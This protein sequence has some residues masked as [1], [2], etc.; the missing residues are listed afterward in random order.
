MTHC[1]GNSPDGDDCRAKVEAPLTGC[2]RSQSQQEGSG[3]KSGAIRSSVTNDSPETSCELLHRRPAN[4]YL[5]ATGCSARGLCPR[6]SSKRKRCRGPC[7]P[8]PSS[9]LLLGSGL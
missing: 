7:T 8:E 5:A 6:R 9:L 4:R 1:S 3:P 2:L